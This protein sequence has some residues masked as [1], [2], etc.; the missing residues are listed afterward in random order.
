VEPYV[1]PG[2]PTLYAEYGNIEKLRKALRA[3]DAI[4]VAV[5]S[6]TLNDIVKRAGHEPGDIHGG[7]P[8][9]HVAIWGPTSSART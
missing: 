7:M 8:P 6:G 3:H 5:A 4:P 2:K 9:R 1:F